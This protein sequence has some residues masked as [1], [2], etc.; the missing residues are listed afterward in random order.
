MT[1]GYG[2]VPGP[3][4][5]I[6]TWI[7]HGRANKHGNHTILLYYILYIIIL[8]YIILYYKY[9]I[10]VYTAYCMHLLQEIGLNQQ[11][12]VDFEAKT[13]SAWVSV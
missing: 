4:W 12:N 9:I 5:T 2:S 7:T 1:L 6:P 3:T 8:Y 13:S 11:E 10:Y